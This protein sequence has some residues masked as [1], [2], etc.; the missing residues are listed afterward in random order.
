ML[1]AKITQMETETNNLKR[2]CARLEA[3]NKNLGRQLLELNSL[4]ANAVAEFH[5]RNIPTG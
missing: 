4:N 5:R 2:E 1:E 3:A